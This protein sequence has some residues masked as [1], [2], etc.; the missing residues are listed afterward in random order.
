MEGWEAKVNTQGALRTKR[1]SH[2][3]GAAGVPARTAAATELTDARR[4]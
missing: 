4:R 1:K 3:R 2:A